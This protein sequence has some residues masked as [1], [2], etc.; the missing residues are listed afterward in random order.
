[1]NKDA[2]NLHTA[3]HSDENNFSLAVSVPLDSPVGQALYS[4]VKDHLDS[5]GINPAIMFQL[6]V[7]INKD[8]TAASELL[9][10][11]KEAEESTHAKH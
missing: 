8:A 4:H 2:T 9:V 6:V 3:V 5:L 1:M 11:S 10:G 7:Q